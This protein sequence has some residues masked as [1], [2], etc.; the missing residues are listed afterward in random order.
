M[1]SRLLTRQCGPFKHDVYLGFGVLDLT[2]LNLLRDKLEQCNVLC[3]LKYD[4]ALCQ[5][6]TKSAVVEGVARSKKCLL[7]VSESFIE[8]QWYNFEVAE[9]LHKAKR[10]SRD[11]VIV[12]KDPQ[13]TEVDMPPALK[14]FTNVRLTVHDD[15]TLDDPEFLRRL[16]TVLMTEPCPSLIVMPKENVGYGSAFGYFY[17]YLRLVL[18]EFQR[19][20]E[21]ETLAGSTELLQ[22]TV[23]KMLIIMPESCF[24]PPQFSEE[25]KIEHTDKFVVRV[26]HRAGNKHRDYKSSLYKIIDQ[27][28]QEEYYF[29]GELATPLLTLYETYL[30]GLS[31]MTRD[32]LYTER[33]CFYFTLNAILSHRDNRACNGQYKLLYWDNDPGMKSS[34]PKQFYEFILPEIRKELESPAVVSDGKVRD[35]LQSDGV[36]NELD[37]NTFETVH[38]RGATPAVIYEPLNP[39]KMDSEPRGL[40]LIINIRQF[41]KA[42]VPLAPRPGA[43]KDAEMLQQL[44]EDLK[45][46][47][48]V[49]KDLTMETLEKLLLTSSAGD[50]SRFDAFVCCLLTHGKLGVL[51]TSDAKPVRILDIVEYFDDLHCESLCGKPKLF[52]IQACLT[53]AGND[54]SP[55][56]SRSSSPPRQLS[57]QS[58]EAIH[59]K[60]VEASENT[61][62][63]TLNQ[64]V[65]GMSLNGVASVQTVA[66]EMEA[67]TLDWD[68]NVAPTLEAADCST[69]AE[70]RAMLV[71]GRPDFLMSYATLPGA[72]AFRDR[73][74]GSLY[75]SQLASCLRQRLEIDRALKLVSRGVSEELRVRDI[76]D[77]MSRFQ[78]P[79]HLT[80]GMD[81]LIML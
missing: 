43:D 13:L 40:C 79:F 63:Q 44:F 7:Y 11:M 69:W 24:C 3:Y 30:Y 52:F 39:Y 62:L 25:G 78:L 72:S 14:E 49:H 18:P 23:R 81:K 59:S 61:Q 32:Q 56:Q 12:L 29:V 53:G 8:D 65:D 64:L 35:H 16:A 74:I 55:T 70:G 51:Y 47:V 54:G 77:S 6:S 67:S 2:K 4:A 38:V 17:G 33:D 37:V 31:G 26:A 42:P 34:T 19:R 50:H 57:V 36:A 75:V 21:E 71:P 80:T 27:T 20:L 76:E 45:F 58:D 15:G 73:E 9:V 60:P 68:A 66:T 28:S 22:R 10:F 46:E 48:E 1:E 5:K 41:E